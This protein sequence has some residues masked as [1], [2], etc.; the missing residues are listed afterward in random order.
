VT[1]AGWHTTKLA[2][3]AVMGNVDFR[4]Y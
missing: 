3:A 2:D 1:S 4:K